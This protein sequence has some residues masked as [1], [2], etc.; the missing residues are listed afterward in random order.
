M[1]HVTST[2]IA[3]DP[4]IEQDLPDYSGEVLQVVSFD[5][6]TEEYAVDILAV[7]EIIRMVEITKVPKAPYYVEGVINLRGKVIP[8]IDLRLRFGLPPAERT[9]ET[10]IVVVDVSDIILGLIVDSVTE[11][12]RI[13]SSLIEPPP[14]GKQGGAEFHKGIGRINGRLLI[15]LDLD[16]LLGR[17]S[18]F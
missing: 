7:Q 17:D 13:P 16:R 12:I 4:I 11:V 1:L 9:K 14:N 18:L 10:R 8:I 15:L 2:P 3:N 6:G 5:I